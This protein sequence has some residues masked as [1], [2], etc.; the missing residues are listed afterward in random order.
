M[1]PIGNDEEIIFI[2]T[3]NEDKSI[4][5]N[6]NNGNS[7]GNSSNSTNINGNNNNI[8]NDNNNNDNNIS[9]NN[10]INNNHYYININNNSN[11]INI[12]SN[13]KININNNNNSRDSDRFNSDQDNLLL[14]ELDEQ[15]SRLYAKQKKPKSASEKKE[16]KNLAKYDLA[17]V[18]KRLHPTHLAYQNPKGRQM[19]DSWGNHI[20]EEQEIIRWFKQQKIT[21]LPTSMRGMFDRHH[22]QKSN[23]NQDGSEEEEESLSEEEKAKEKRMKILRNAIKK[24]LGLRSENSAENSHEQP[25][26]QQE[27]AQQ[28]PQQQQQQ[29]QQAQQQQQQQ[30][31]QEQEARQQQQP[32]QEQ[33]EI[34]N[35]GNLE[36]LNHEQQQEPEQQQQQQNQQQ[37]QQQQ[38]ELPSPDLIRSLIRNINQE[39]KDSFQE[40]ASSTSET[41][42]SA[43]S[44]L[45]SSPSST[46]VLVHSITRKDKLRAFLIGFV[47]GSIFNYFK[48][49]LK[50]WFPSPKHFSYGIETPKAFIKKI[51]SIPIFGRREPPPAAVWDSFFTFFGVFAGISAIGAL[52]QYVLAP[53]GYPILYAAFG[54]SATLIFSLPNVGPSQMRNVFMGSTIR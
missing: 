38:V 31:Q 28:Q 41:N 45:T 39:I 34:E 23:A 24:T 53:H 44:S 9:S 48:K 7:S 14:K 10:N 49:L 26:Q 4:L 29:Q 19:Y 15:L 36:Q 13:N 33:P 43:A 21:T 2:E 22:R 51:M 3:I 25:Q 11:N 18:I 32:P 17:Y 1:N 40:S 52:S 46:S 5:S 47:L 54:S 35:P 50:N 27:Q 6:N 30:N 8:I 16:D 37:Q 42:A 20:S 12:S